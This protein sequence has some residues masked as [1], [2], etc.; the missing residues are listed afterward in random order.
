MLL[1]TST[2]KIIAYKIADGQVDGNPVQ[3]SG[4][5]HSVTQLINLPNIEDN[6]A[7]IMVTGKNA[8]S[9]YIHNKKDSR[10]V[11][12]GE[13]GQQYEGH[14][15]CNVKAA[16]N[17]KFFMIGVPSKRAIGFFGLNRVQLSTKPLKWI[18]KV[19]VVI[20]S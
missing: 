15:I 9:I 12:F 8:L 3:V 5:E 20:Y 18:T 7:Y 4:T 19:S 2:G 6:N 17:N 11:D 13:V 1:G 14:D 16:L 10:E